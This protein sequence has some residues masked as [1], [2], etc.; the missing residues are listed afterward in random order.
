MHKALWDS[1]CYLY[2]DKQITYTLLLVAARKAEAV[3]LEGKGTT[4]I[5]KTKA[6]NPQF[7]NFSSEVSELY[8]QLANLMS[9]V[10]STQTNSTRGQNVKGQS[11]G[12]EP[13][14]KRDKGING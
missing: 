1:I 11:Q 3:V 8:Q 10:K 6:A 9:I 2:D 14:K 7:D 5:P 13:Q 12:K 4:T